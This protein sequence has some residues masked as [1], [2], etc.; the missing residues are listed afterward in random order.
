LHVSIIEPGVIATPIWQTSLDN[1]TNTMSRMP[2]KA[3]TYYGPIIDA[4][5]R[6]V[7]GGLTRGLP[8]HDVAKV[9][10]HALFSAKPKTRYMI[11]R[12][13]LARALFQRL[14]DRWRDRVINRRL[15]R[16]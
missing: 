7:Q 5:T 16:L 10:E 6:M 12:D 14:P 2:A 8:P 15:R 13:A 9:V 11:G 4:V 3:R 1:A